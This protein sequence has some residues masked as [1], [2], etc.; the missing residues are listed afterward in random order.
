[1]EGFFDLYNFTFFKIDNQRLIIYIVFSL[2]KRWK[3]SKFAV[4]S[5]RNKALVW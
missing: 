4:L 5:H 3:K 1:M 2:L